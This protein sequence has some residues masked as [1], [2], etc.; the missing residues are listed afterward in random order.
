MNYEVLLFYKYTPIQD[1]HQTA[2]WV[3]ML[4]AEY[5]LLGRVIVAAEGIN[6]TL[7][8]LHEHTQAFVNVFTAD[9]RFADIP[10]KTSAGNGSSFP[11]LRVKV[12]DEIVGT[13]FPKHIDPT[14]QTGK[15][16]TPHQLRAL[17]E[18]GEDFTLI[19]MRNSYEIASGA[20]KGAVDPGMQNSRDLPN[21]I[22]KL[23]SHKHKKVV[24]VC[25]G[26]VRCEKMSA[27]LIDQGFTDVHQL[28]GGIHVYLEQYPDK[29]FEGVLYTF[30]NRATIDFGG[31]RARIGTCAL[32]SAPTETYRDC[33]T[34]TCRNH[35]LAC[36][37]C[38]QGKHET[39]CARC[40]KQNKN[41]FAT[42][43]RRVFART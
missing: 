39:A 24:T 35:F 17:Y 7:E 22:Q 4:C 30:D 11:K 41:F 38:A 12:R 37:S 3:R 6:A 13:H 26:G 29:D 16:L 32:C 25:T 10:I 18:S 15:R 42:L 9:T 27:Y 19:D 34:P 31:N 28:D 8:G 21:T 1:P 5:N 43:W 40:R 23:A 33:A 20:F 14:V 2:Q 36:D